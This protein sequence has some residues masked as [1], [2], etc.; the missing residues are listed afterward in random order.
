[1]EYLK[2]DS[3]RLSDD[4]SSVIIIDQTLLPN[5]LIYKKLNTRE[6]IFEA[7]KNLRVRGAPAIGIC[8]GYAMYVLSLSINAV[9]GEKF[10]NE[11]L[12]IGEY[13]CSSRLIL[14]FLL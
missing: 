3:V 6:D 2:N 11:L 9:S 5:D 1:M 4:G 13:L 12:Q 8:A 14:P 7:I 10:L